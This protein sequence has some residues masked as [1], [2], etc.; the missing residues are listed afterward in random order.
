MIRK[1]LPF[2]LLV[3]I[4][5]D[6]YDG[7]MAVSSKR[8]DDIYVAIA[9]ADNL[10]NVVELSLNNDDDKYYYTRKIA[11]N[12]EER[13]Q[14]YGLNSWYQLATSKENKS[15]FIFVFPEDTILKHSWEEIKSN[16]EY[17]RKI[18]LSIGDLESLGWHVEIY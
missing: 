16:N 1:L 8:V 6:K 17:E 2:I 3:F 4:S 12:S 18:E 13:I 11:S 15:L 7:R 10:D 14:K 9:N 5:C